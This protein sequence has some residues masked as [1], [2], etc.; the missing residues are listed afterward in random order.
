MIDGLRFVR[1]VNIRFDFSEDLFV[2][3]HL[4]SLRH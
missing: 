1:E 3:V 4:G 2:V